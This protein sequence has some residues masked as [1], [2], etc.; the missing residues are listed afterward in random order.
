MRGGG[1]RE[2]SGRASSEV[3]S[4]KFAN[5][6]RLRQSYRDTLGHPA[7][8]CSCLSLRK[9][10][11]SRKSVLLQQHFPFSNARLLEVSIELTFKTKDPARHS[12]TLR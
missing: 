1:W 5:G 3:V 10:V 2:E 6:R 12:G 4:E 8:G 11:Y 9:C 7:G